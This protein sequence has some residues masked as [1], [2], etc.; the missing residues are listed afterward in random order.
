MQLRSKESHI[1]E[2]KEIQIKRVEDMMQLL[3][4][5]VLPSL[6]PGTRASIS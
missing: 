2:L 1:K 4:M 3:S 6:E 5:A